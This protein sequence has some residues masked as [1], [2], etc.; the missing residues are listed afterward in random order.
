MN[1]AAHDDEFGEGQRRVKLALT[2]G[3]VARI[4]DLDEAS[5]VGR[6]LHFNRTLA[7]IVDR[8]HVKALP[9]RYAGRMP[10]C[11]EWLSL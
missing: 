8:G 2:N 6:L 11:S 1:A 10:A 7:A 9:S 3:D 5:C 4:A